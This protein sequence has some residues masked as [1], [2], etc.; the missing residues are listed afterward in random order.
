MTGP[1]HSPSWN[2]TTA[3][4]K[5]RDRWI[6]LCEQNESWSTGEAERWKA[7]LVEEELDYVQATGLLMREEFRQK[8]AMRGGEASGY[9]DGVVT[10]S[11][12][13]TPDEM[14]RKFEEL[15][16]P[17]DEWDGVL[18]CMYMVLLEA[19]EVGKK[20]PF[21]VP[22]S[23][24]PDDD[25]ETEDYELEEHDIVEMDLDGDEGDES[26]EDASSDNGSGSDEG[27]MEDMDVE[28]LKADAEIEL[29]VLVGKARDFVELPLRQ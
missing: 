3:L 10:W 17:V 2:L 12:K 29:D 11:A 23:Q 1:T 16:G 8:I 24:I 14:I 15:A 25:D 6:D 28:V 9:E 22:L 21:D 18:K 7:K 27:D 20:Y 5:M 4:Y 13:C 19:H 26:M